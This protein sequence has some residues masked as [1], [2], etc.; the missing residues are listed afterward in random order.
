M[1]QC[2]PFFSTHLC[3][4][5]AEY[6]TDRSEKVAFPRSVAP[7]DNIVF[8]RKGLDDSLLLVAILE[9]NGIIC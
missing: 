8:R 7:N 4:C 2:L 5:I 9:V 6:E 3:I 1:K